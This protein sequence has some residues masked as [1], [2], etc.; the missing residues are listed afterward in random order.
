MN[1]SQSKTSQMIWV[2]T[3]AIP[4]FL[5]EV[6]IVYTCF[7]YWKKVTDTGTWP[8]KK[9]RDTTNLELELFTQEFEE[10]TGSIFDS[11]CKCISGA[12][13]VNQPVINQFLIKEFRHYIH[14]LRLLFF[15]VLVCSNRSQEVAELHLSC[16]HSKLI[17]HTIFLSHLLFHPSIL[18]Q[19]LY[20]IMDVNAT[21]TIVQV[22]CKNHAEILK[23]NMFGEGDSSTWVF[24]V[25][26]NFITNEFGK[27][28]GDK[29]YSYIINI[30]SMDNR[31]WVKQEKKQHRLF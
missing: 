25:A 20:Q 27:Y 1:A 8:K 15:L 10:V 28:S 3:T 13:C 9:R 30:K 26:G 14:R 6:L 31:F 18:Q 19:V 24:H 2:V 21:V 16:F 17:L 29:E 12:T 4:N 11:F 5:S 7:C 22:Q 23:T